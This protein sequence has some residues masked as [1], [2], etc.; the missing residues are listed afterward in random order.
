M[1][2]WLLTWV[3]E[4]QTQSSCVSNKLLPPALSPQPQSAFTL[5]GVLSDFTFGH[6]E[7]HVRGKKIFNVNTEIHGLKS[8][9]FYPSRLC[10]RQCSFFGTN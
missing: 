8:V 6:L 10:L 5:L 4:P 2:A 1:P 9:D 3:L 7:P